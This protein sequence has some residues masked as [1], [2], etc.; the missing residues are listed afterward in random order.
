MN[1]NL[2]VKSW[3][4]EYQQIIK[5]KF[6]NAKTLVG[7][8]YLLEV[9]NKNFGDMQVKNVT[10]ARARDL[11]NIYVSSGKTSQAK[12]MHSLLSDMFNECILTGYIEYNPCWPLKYPPQRVKRARLLLDE[13]RKLYSYSLNYDSDGFMHKLLILSLVTA[14]RPG[15]II[16][17]GANRRDYHIKDGYLFIHQ[18][19]GRQCVFVDGDKKLIKCGSKIAIPLSLRLNEFDISVQDA[20]NFCDGKEY[21]IEYNNKKLSYSRVNRAFRALRDKVF[22]KTYW[23][24]YAA[25]SFFEIRSL[26]ERL[27]RE[28][29]VNTQILLGHKYRT[30]TDSYNDL[31]GRGWTYLKK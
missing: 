29:G 2:T 23:G 15:D 22:D 24:D 14:Q 21:F 9:I 26:S 3:I 4:T 17:M 31:R 8:L 20:I 27:Y 10:P 6:T 25:P 1:S 18:Q 5:T 16:E 19:K 12:A 11:I 28:Q 13:F 30:T 7:K